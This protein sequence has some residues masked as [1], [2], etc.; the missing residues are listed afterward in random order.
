MQ[1]L[2]YV[3]IYCVFYTSVALEITW[4]NSAEPD[5]NNVGSDSFRFQNKM[6]MP[7]WFFIFPGKK[8]QL[9]CNLLKRRMI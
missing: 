3:V 2:E 5:L 1:K 6:S 9:L 8:N 7:N 4:D